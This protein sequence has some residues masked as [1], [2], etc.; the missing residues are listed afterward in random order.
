MP[1]K[2]NTSAR[3]GEKK[4]Q[5]VNVRDI[6]PKTLKALNLMGQARHDVV[7]G[8]LKSIDKRLKC[9]ETFQAAATWE[10]MHGD[11]AKPTDPPPSEN[12]VPEV[13]EWV[14]LK[15]ESKLRQVTEV[16]YIN[17]RSSPPCAYGKNPDWG[18]YVHN[19]RKPSEAEIAE[20]KRSE[21]ARLKSEQEAKELAMP[22][23]MGARVRF[24]DTEDWVLSIPW[25]DSDGDYVLARHVPGR[26]P[27]PF[28]IDYCKRD[29]FSVIP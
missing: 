13:G 15:G 11:D 23:K 26:E 18:A 28:I 5:A 6:H 4:K 22:L 12:W 29:K 2:T 19:L 10:A 14:A 25:P 3:K 7:V 17:D 16:K 1:T 27:A 21:E 9:V 24:R 8:W 20:H